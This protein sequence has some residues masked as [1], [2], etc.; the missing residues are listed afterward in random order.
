MCV[1]ELLINKGVTVNKLAKKLHVGRGV[2]Y[3]SIN[4][5]GSRQ[6]RIVIAKII[7]SKPS[8]LW[9]DNPQFKKALDDA[10][11]S[12]DSDSLRH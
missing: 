1:R 10:L 3:Q 9:C 2:I 5:D 7:G 11:F 12:L 4:G 6:I 8:V